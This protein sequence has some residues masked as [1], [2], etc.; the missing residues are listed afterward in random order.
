MSII[1]RKSTIEF[2]ANLGAVPY[3]ELVKV[4]Y[5][6][7]DE[8]LDAVDVLLSYFKDN[9]HRSIKDHDELLS[10]VLD[11]L[12]AALDGDVTIDRISGVR[13]LIKKLSKVVI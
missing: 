13:R 7:N 3:I 8:A 6:F 4:H 1:T 5:H 10:E 12:D 11:T 9:T 2:F